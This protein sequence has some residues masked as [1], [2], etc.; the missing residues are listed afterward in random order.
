[1]KIVSLDVHTETSQLCLSDEDGTIVLEMQVATQAEAL[2][3]VI[4]GIAGPKCVVFE[5]GPLSAMISDAVRDLVDEVISCEPAHNAL[6]AR[7]EDANDERDARRL[8]E[9][10]RLRAVRS[11][12][13]PQEPCR[14]LRSL[15]VYDLGLAGQLVEVRNKIKGLCR[16]NGI[17][18]AGTGVY[19]RSGRQRVLAKLGSAAMRWQMESLYRLLD[20]LEA[21]RRRA[22]KRTGS[23]AKKVGPVERLCTIPGV[24]PMVARTLVAWIAEPQRFRSRSSLCSYGGLGLGQGWTNWQPVGRARASRR[25]NRCVKR[26]LFLA[27]RAASRGHS[28][29]GRRYRARREAGW[30]DRKAIRDTARVILKTAVALWRKGTR[31]DDAAVSV[32]RTS[33]PEASGC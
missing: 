17:P 13:V 27:A 25:G 20:A 10:T 1:M 9:L 15:L 19:A 7:A 2:R 23:L 28:A 6:I 8:A 4:G 12:Y 33:N 24:G 29:L 32:P 16:R 3:R 31:Y 22:S 18:S 11:V 21:E 26:A 5:E 14:S 30:E